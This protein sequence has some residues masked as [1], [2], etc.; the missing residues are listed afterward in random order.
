MSDTAPHFLTVGTDA[1]ARRIAV[2]DRP[3][4]GPGLLWLGGFMS[5]MQGTKAVA[6]DEW[7]ARAGRAVTRQGG[8]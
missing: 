6:L 2:R 8:R 1:G 7:G 5:D 4:A 3:G